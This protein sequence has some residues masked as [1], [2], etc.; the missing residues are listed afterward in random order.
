MVSGIGVCQG[1]GV[2]LGLTYLVSA[3]SS[4][5]DLINTQLS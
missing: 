2:K 4:D 1:M 3:P 5:N